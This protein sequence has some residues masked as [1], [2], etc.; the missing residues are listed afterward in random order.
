MAHPCEVGQ[1]P[2]YPKHRH[3]HQRTWLHPRRRV[4]LIFDFA[5]DAPPTAKRRPEPGCM[6]SRILRRVVLS[7][8]NPPPCPIRNAELLPRRWR[9]GFRRLNT[10]LRNR[11]RPLSALE[12]GLWGRGLAR[13]T[14]ATSCVMGRTRGDLTPRPPLRSG[15]GTGHETVWNP[16]RSFVIRQPLSGRS[17]DR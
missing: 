12:R 14:S 15:E 1:T 6:P 3:H 10:A 17:N 2:T 4:S 8:R 11:S 13:R 5:V 7:R 16:S 9:D